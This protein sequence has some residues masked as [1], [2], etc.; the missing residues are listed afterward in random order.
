MDN[1][2]D[3]N[4]YNDI[5]RLHDDNSPY[6]YDTHWNTSLSKL[7]NQPNFGIFHINIRSLAAH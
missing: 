2:P 4:F 5:Q 7:A 3:I 6:L 1:D